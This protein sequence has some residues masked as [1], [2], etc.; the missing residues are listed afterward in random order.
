[1]RKPGR[2]SPPRIPSTIRPNPE[3][4]GQTLWDA[5]LGGF[6]GL[7]MDAADSNRII[8]ASINAWKPQ[9]WETSG[10][11]AWGDK[12]FVTV[13]R[14]K[15]L[16]E[17]VRRFDRRPDRRRHRRR[18]HRRSRQERV[19]L[20]RRRKHPLGRQP[21]IRSFQFQARFRD[22]RQR[23]LHDGQ[24]VPGPAVQ[25]EFQFP[26]VGGNRSFRRGQHTGR[27]PHHRHRRLR[28]FR[29]PRHHAAP[30]GAA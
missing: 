19:R 7:S 27:T 16:E 3:L 28:R 20:D 12:M 30:A 5:H 24:S 8:A 9:I 18:A 26:R 2:T 21:G 17:P 25:L 23:R 15:D 6:G 29:A 11:P 1:M 4:P 14:R 10:K 22:V 13:R